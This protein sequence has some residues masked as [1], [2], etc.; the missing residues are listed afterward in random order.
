MPGSIFYYLLI[1]LSA[2]LKGI[3]KYTRGRGRASEMVKV[4]HCA[5]FCDVIV[6]KKWGSA[7]AR[8]EIMREPIPC[9]LG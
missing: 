7:H 9:R 3:Y 4:G 2:K 8:E 5:V 6:E 1:P